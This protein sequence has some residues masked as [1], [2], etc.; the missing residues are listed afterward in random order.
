[1]TLG[2]VRSHHTA[3]MRHRVLVKYRTTEYDNA[4]QPIETFVTRFPSEPA[5]YEQVAGGEFLRGRKIDVNTTVIFT[6]NYRAGYVETDIIT[7]D[8]VDY[9]IVKLDIP[10]GIKRYIEIQAKR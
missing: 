9:G 10:E 5:S 3:K 4:G 8:G 6:V 2:E 7:F 1:M